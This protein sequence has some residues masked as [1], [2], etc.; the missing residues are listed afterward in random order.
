MD[1]E[2]ETMSEF[3]ETEK[4]DPKDA[5]IPEADEKEDSVNRE[6]SEQEKLKLKLEK[7]EAEKNELLILTQRVQADFDNFRRRTRL[8]KEEL[9]K[10][11]IEGLV[12]QLLPVIDN[13]ERALHS[14]KDGGETQG[15]I[16]GVDMIFRQLLQILTNEGV[17]PIEAVGCKFD[18]N[19]H[20]AV[21]QIEEEGYEKDT[22]IEEFQ[23]GY[24]FK[25]KLIR[26]SMVKVAK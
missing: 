11:G 18:P 20:E 10:Y 12:S 13:F 23:K 22:V 14:A 19:C 7:L 25:E 4:R 1:K 17:T 9:L 5:V 2:K 15:F 6:I 16:E 3:N 21:M 24:K 26:P 8:E